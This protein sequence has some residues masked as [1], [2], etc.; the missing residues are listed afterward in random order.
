MIVRKMVRAK[1]RLKAS[2][3]K[4]QTRSRVVLIRRVQYFDPT[5][6]KRNSTTSSN[7]NHTVFPQVKM[8][9]FRAKAHLV[10][11]WYFSNNIHE[12]ITIF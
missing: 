11:H 4:R 7:E 12:K 2:T 8:S 5:K 1:Y 6:L 10:F 3:D 9:C